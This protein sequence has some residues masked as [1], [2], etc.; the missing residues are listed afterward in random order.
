MEDTIFT[1][2]IVVIAAVIQLDI[3]K[4]WKYRWALE[5][6]Q[7]A[8][9]WTYNEYVRGWKKDT[10][11]LTD[12][13][14]YEARKIAVSKAVDIAKDRGIDLGKV[15]GEENL[16]NFVEMAVARAKK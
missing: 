9:T 8:V 2:V 3:V 13:Q 5:I 6:V 10:P 11:K 15:L 7:L 16:D 14:R 4:K 12:E 1:I